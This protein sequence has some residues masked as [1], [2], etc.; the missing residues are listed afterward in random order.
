MINVAEETWDAFQHDV[1]MYVTANVKNTI[2]FAVWYETGG[3]DI[4][5][6]AAE[7]GGKI[8]ELTDD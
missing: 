1:R 2:R 4:H 8:E 6:I 7:V 3:G 5:E